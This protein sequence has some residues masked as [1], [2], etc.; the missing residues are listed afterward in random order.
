MS[1]IGMRMKNNF[2]IK[3]WAPTLVLKQRSGGTRKWSIGWNFLR[4]RKRCSCFNKVFKM[5]YDWSLGRIKR[6]VFTAFLTSPRVTLLLPMKMWKVISFTCQKK[7]SCKLSIV[8]VFLITN[9][10][11]FIIIQH[12]NQYYLPEVKS[13]LAI[14]CKIVNCTTG[15]SLSKGK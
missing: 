14:D 11:W 7:P 2:H 5:E 8:R 6:Q 1:F 4:N 3:G 9:W 15:S 10:S 12:T 13:S